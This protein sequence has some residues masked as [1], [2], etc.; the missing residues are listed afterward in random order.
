MSSNEY[1]ICP[2]SELPDGSRLL[3]RMGDMEVGIFNVGGR[4]VAYENRC[5]HQGGPV[6]RGRILGR[7]VEDL[8]PNKEVVGGHHSSDVDIVCPWHGW[9]Y[10]LLTGRNIADPTISL[11]ALE[12]VVRDGVIC[13]RA[14]SPIF[15]A[16]AV[17]AH[18]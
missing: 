18:E 3:A 4:I 15:T 12:V 10:D 6:C 14:G 13:V 1:K 9:E 16:E 2:V 8:G 5:P 7:W 17:P 11:T